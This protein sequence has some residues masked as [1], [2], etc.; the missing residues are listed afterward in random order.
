MHK[1]TGLIVLICL[2][3]YAQ[4]ERTYHFDEGSGSTTGEDDARIMGATWIEGFGSHALRFDPTKMG[5]VNVPGYG[6]ELYGDDDIILTFAAWVRTRDGEGSAA[7]VECP[8]LDYIGLRLYQ[9]KFTFEFTEWQ[10]GPFAVTEQ[11]YNDGKWHYVV[12][13]CNGTNKARIYVDGELAAQ[14]TE[15]SRGNV[16]NAFGDIFVG[17]MLLGDMDEVFISPNEMSQD[18]A[19]R[20]YQDAD[21]AIRDAP[22]LDASVWGSTTVKWGAPRSTPPLGRGAPATVLPHAGSLPSGSGVVIYNVK[23]RVMRGGASAAG[24]ISGGTYLLRP[25]E[26]EASSS[27]RMTILGGR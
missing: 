26:G 15:D 6:E 21:P 11:T 25:A 7:I 18:E 22:A 17:G 1:I 13:T 3:V 27:R 12:G 10:G 2:A 9:G 19:R 24:G 20:R 16:V 14:A 23:G 4:P 5:H 8:V